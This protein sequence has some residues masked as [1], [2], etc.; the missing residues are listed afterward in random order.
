M[1]GSFSEEEAAAAAAVVV[2]HRN[3]F[4]IYISRMLRRCV[5]QDQ[6]G[7]LVGW[8]AGEI[9]ALTDPIIVSTFTKVRCPE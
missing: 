2:F 5:V 6:V 4:P 7:W 3:K 9:G 8:L 1:Y